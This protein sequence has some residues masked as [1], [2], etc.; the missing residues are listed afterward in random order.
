MASEGMAGSPSARVR[1]QAEI[2]IVI[3]V[4]HF[5]ALC[6]P[7]RI[8]GYPKTTGSSNPYEP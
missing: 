1:S 4:L 6:P 2:R 8:K 7:A 5:S 3:L